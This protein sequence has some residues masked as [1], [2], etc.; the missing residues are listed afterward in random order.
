MVSAFALAHCGLMW[1]FFTGDLFPQSKDWKYLTSVKFS[2]PDYYEDTAKYV[3]E[4][5]EDFK[6]FSVPM[7]RGRG[8]QGV[9][10][11]WGSAGSDP[12]IQLFNKRLH[13]GRVQQYYP[14]IDTLETLIVDHPLVAQEI[15]KLN[16]IRFILL[17]ND[18]RKNFHEMNPPSVFA[19][20]FSVM[21]DVEYK[22]TFGEIDLFEINK[23]EKM[24]YQTTNIVLSP[25]RFAADP[26]YIALSQPEAS[27]KPVYINYSSATEPK[28]NRTSVLPFQNQEVLTNTV[29]AKSATSYSFHL[30]NKTARKRFCNCHV[31]G[32]SMD[33]S[34]I[35]VILACLTQFGL[36]S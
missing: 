21:P 23:I 33:G 15:L 9:A 35:R 26:I 28:A 16:N 11:D 12:Q 31:S 30:T 18:I 32:I 34:F 14:Y 36:K 10:Y 27:R 6:I 17:H 29:V 4:L 5:E 3:N 19:D 7:R 25:E 22:M 2:L 24:I 8:G 1:P 13:I 20:A